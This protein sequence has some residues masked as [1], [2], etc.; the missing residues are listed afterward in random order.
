M[1]YIKEV[2]ALVD[3]TNAGISDSSYRRAGANLWS[4]KLDE[5]GREVVPREP[6]L[7]DAL[8]DWVATSRAA[9]NA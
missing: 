2:N 3:A 9:A 5:L 7:R 4:E 8:A 6:E 1:A